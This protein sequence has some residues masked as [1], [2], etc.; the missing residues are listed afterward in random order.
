MYMANSNEEEP[1]RPKGL[2]IDTDA[3]MFETV[4]IYENPII[5]NDL[6]KTYDGVL[7]DF[8]RGNW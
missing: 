1:P 5:L 8:F 3:P 4:D 6:L 2:L 7:L